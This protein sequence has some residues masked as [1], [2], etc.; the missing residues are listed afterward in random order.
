[1]NG[2][3]DKGQ[4][5]IKPWSH[6]G[7]GRCSRFDLWICGN[8]HKRGSTIIKFKLAVAKVMSDFFLMASRSRGGA[9]T[10]TFDGPTSVVATTMEMIGAATV[11]VDRLRKGAVWL[12]SE[13]RKEEKEEEWKEEWK[14]DKIG[15]LGDL[16]QFLAFEIFLKP[17]E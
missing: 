10:L 3:N 6:T 1:M 15:S 9:A 8:D 14:G 4:I 16:N 13:E 11:A 2:I 7:D 5:K 17:W 12:A